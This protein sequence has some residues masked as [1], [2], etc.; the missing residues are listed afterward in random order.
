MVV[1]TDDLRRFPF[2]VLYSSSFFLVAPL[3]LVA[4][5]P[6]LQT[7]EVLSE[8][9]QTAFYA[10]LVMLVVLLLAVTFYMPKLSKTFRIV[11]LIDLV[12]LSISSIAWF[13]VIYSL[14]L[15]TQEPLE[16]SD[17]FT[18]SV[19]VF[20]SNGLLPELDYSNA[21]H[22]IVTQALLGFLFVPMLISSIYL[23]ISGANG[24]E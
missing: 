14:V 16:F 7:Y 24:A 22:L 11:C 12:V 20:T 23:S 21:K 2:L 1:S 9:I 13:A 3:L 5:F 6:D 4:V 17:F 19:M 15:P 10:V 8:S 18:L